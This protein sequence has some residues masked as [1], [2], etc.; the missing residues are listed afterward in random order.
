MKNVEWIMDLSFHLDLRHNG[1]AGRQ[2]VLWIDLIGFKNNLH[3]DALDNLD[4]VA[5]RILRRE[6]AESRAGAGL[7]A[8]HVPVKSFVRISVHGDLS[9]LAW[10]HFSYLALFKICGDPNLT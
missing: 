1:H 3:R 2:H 4:I 10:T 8:V 6:Q 7:N 9:R 5:G